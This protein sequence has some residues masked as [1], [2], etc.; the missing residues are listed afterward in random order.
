MLKKLTKEEVIQYAKSVCL[1]ITDDEI[2]WILRKINDAIVATNQPVIARGE[3]TYNELQEIHNKME[4]LLGKQG[5]YIDKIYFC[6]HHPH[7]GYEGEISELKIDCECRKPKPGMLLKAA[8][9]YNIELS[10]SW[11]IGDGEN[12]IK[13]GKTAGSK[14]VLVGAG[15][16][17]Q[18][19][20]AANLLEAVESILT[21]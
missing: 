21:V 20:T 10:Q 15:D 5:A 13:A 12:D 6:P 2:D 3:V 17:G 8:E 7:K 16:Y 1:C 18:D 11:M 4:T 19:V 9:D 14:T